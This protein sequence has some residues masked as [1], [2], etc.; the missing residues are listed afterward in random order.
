[1]KVLIALVLFFALCLQANAAA[2]QIIIL[3]A[4]S[5]GTNTTVTYVF[6][7]TTSSP[8][9]VPG[10]GSVWQGASAAE[11]AAIVAGTTIERPGSLSGLSKAAIKTALQNA[12]N[13]SQTAI[14]AVNN[15]CFFDG[16]VWSC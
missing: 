8:V 6:W 16:T 3:T 5:D 15:G 12:Y 10:R 9:P 14:N 13:Q 7:L 11:N 2:K 1:M 4:D